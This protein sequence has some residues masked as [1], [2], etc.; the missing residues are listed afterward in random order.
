ML[1]FLIV[2]YTNQ[3]IRIQWGSSMS[4]ISSVSNGLMEGGV[5]SPIL[6]TVYIDELLSRL[7]AAKLGCYIGNIFVGL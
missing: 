7:S 4:T 2:F 5:L 6:F 1:R 3:R